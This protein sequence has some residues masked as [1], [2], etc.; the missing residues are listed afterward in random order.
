MRFALP[1]KSKRFLRRTWPMTTFVLTGYS[2][3]ART[4]TGGQTGFLT[5]AD[6]ELVVSGSHAIDSNNTSPDYLTVNGTLAANSNATLSAVNVVGGGMFMIVGPSGFVSAHRGNAIQ[7][8][9]F[10]WFYVDN[11]G[12]ILSGLGDAVNLNRSDSA[13]WFSVSNTGIIQGHS[14]GVRLDGGSQIS[15][16]VNSGTITGMSGYGIGANY[17]AD[18]TGTSILHNTGTIIGVSGSYT[19]DSGTGANIIFNAGV[20]NGDISLG[21]G[22][23]RYEGGSGKVSG[24]IDGGD[25]NDTLSGGALHDDFD[26]GNGDDTLAG[27]SGDDAL[28]GDSGNDF[29][30]G[31]DGND[32]MDGGADD[33]TLNG[34]SGDDSILGSDGNDILVGQDGSDNLEGGADNDTL[35]G[36]AGDD[37]LEG[38]DGND[39]L[40]GRNGEDEL[41]GGL[42]RD[43]LTGGQGADNFVFRALTETVVGANRDQILDFEQGVDMIVVAGLSPGVFEFKGTGAFDTAVANP[44]LRLFET[45]TGSTIVQ[46]DAN[47]DGVADAAIRVAGVTGLTVDDFVL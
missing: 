18:S 42:G 5:N 45:A 14:D 6:A 32:D 8:N 27:R 20:M 29:I 2:S 11:A 10:N 37:V 23:D 26:G 38:G 12:T 39:I 15:R 33:D 25:D 35:D 41:A 24:L 30:L 13:A 4:L 31:G 3:V 36:G 28:D 22:N 16:I 34:N 19:A 17:A 9:V 7:G 43:F 44:E 47:G 21:A 1:S 46:I 40:R